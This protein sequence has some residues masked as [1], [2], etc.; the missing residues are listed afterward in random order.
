[1]RIS[2]RNKLKGKVVRLEAGAVNTLLEIELAAPPTI[3]AIVTKD[4]VTELDLNVG[5]QACAV[6][7]ASDVLLGVC[8]ESAA[9][10]AC[11]GI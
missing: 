1:M 11:Q 9:N 7:K 10:C 6:I 5:S 3:T 4:A 2:A 8:Q